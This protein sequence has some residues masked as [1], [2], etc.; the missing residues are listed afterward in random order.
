MFFK[1]NK[2]KKIQT[3][4]EQQRKEINS[5][6]ESFGKEG[7]TR[8]EW[9]TVHGRECRSTGLLMWEKDLQHRYTFANTRHCNDFYRISL[10]RVQTLIG[11]TDAE[12]IP[13]FIQRTGLSN[14]FGDLCVSTDDYTAE[15]KATCRFWEFGYVG[16]DIL[17]LD[18][19]KQP[20]YDKQNNIKGTR[21]WASNNSHKECEIKALLSLF[22]QTGEAKM[23][24]KNKDTAAY[25]ITKKKNPFNRKFPGEA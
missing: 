19:T 22:L 2:L 21:S 17:I 10:A 1:N 23:L 4:L 6:I 16:K 3:D 25:L 12:L 13:E 14:S 18:V 7:R 24:S 20:L 15:H 8:I 9:C 11:K 5:Y